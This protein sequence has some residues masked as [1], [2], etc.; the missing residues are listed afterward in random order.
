VEKFL[1]AG[2]IVQKIV[3]NKL[4]SQYGENQNIV[5]E[6]VSVVSNYY[7]TSYG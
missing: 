2:I 4:K 7:Q 3:L 1:A 6:A 5:Q